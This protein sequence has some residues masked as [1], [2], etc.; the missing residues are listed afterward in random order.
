MID[1]PNWAEIW[2][3]DA[4]SSDFHEEQE[5]ML[6]TRQTLCTVLNALHRSNSIQTY[7]GT[8][9]AEREL[10]ELLEARATP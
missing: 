5:L 3:G 4:Q 6:V 8:L 9:A 1:R 10:R 2:S 7:T